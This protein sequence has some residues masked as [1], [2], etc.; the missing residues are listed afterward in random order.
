MFFNRWTPLS[1][2]QTLS[3]PS[4]SRRKTLLPTQLSNCSLYPISR[5]EHVANIKFV[6]TR[7]NC[8]NIH[9]LY[10][11][12]CLS[13]ASVCL[14]W[15]TTPARTQ[16]S[17]RNG[18]HIEHLTNISHSVTSHDNSHEKRENNKI[19]HSVHN[20]HTW[21]HTSTTKI[22]G[23]RKQDYYGKMMCHV[24]ASFE[25]WLRQMQALWTPL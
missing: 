5:G 8:D 12:I 23:L 25:Q 15:T 9:Q 14:T 2:S 21:V 3:C 7:S 16:L 1:W 11:S 22:I 24:S 6:Y 13:L 19:K 17:A 4:P 10:L 18:K 20:L